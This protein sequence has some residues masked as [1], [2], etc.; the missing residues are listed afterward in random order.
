MIFLLICNFIVVAKVLFFPQISKPIA[1]TIAKRAKSSRLFR[2]YVCIPVAQLFHWYDVRVRMRILNLGKATAVPKLN[3]EKAIETGSQLLSEFIILSVASSVV[4]YEWRRSAEKEEAR[5]AEA[6]K[7]RDMLHEKVSGLEM[8]VEEQRTQI[9]EL[10]RLSHSIAEKQQKSSLTGFFG[11]KSAKTDETA[12]DSVKDVSSTFADAGQ[13]TVQVTVEVGAVIGAVDSLVGLMCGDCEDED[14]AEG[15]F[16]PRYLSAVPYWTSPST[17]DP[18]S[19][20]LA[21]L[22]EEQYRP[23]AV[24]EA[25][26]HFLDRSWE[27]KE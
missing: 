4:V 25:V 17:F 20:S 6:D 5:I 9:R 18:Y 26:E 14:N 11:G 24:M 23:G 19:S 21:P 12:P 2:E 22:E 8:A 10:T 27:G 15:L 3:Q 1:N 16:L 7:E 13:E